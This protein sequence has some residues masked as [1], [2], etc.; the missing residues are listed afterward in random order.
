MPAE[1]GA[2]IQEGVEGSC[3]PC[4]RC[5]ASS[6]IRTSALQRTVQRSSSRG[7]IE[8]GAGILARQHLALDDLERLRGRAHTA[9]SRNWQSGLACHTCADGAALLVDAHP[10]TALGADPVEYLLH[11][12]PKLNA[13]LDAA[14]IED[15]N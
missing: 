7:P 14:A 9:S 2:S 3:S 12:A 15:L 8:L 11:G 6:G 5:S 4:S 1:F 13:W 10:G